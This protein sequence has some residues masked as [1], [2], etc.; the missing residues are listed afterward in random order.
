MATR[1]V[2]SIGN[3]PIENINITS[4]AGKVVSGYANCWEL[5]CSAVIQSAI[6]VG[7]KVES[8][9]RRYLV[10]SKSGLLLVVCGDA[11]STTLAPSNGAANSLRSF[12]TI[13]AWASESPIN[14]ITSDFVWKGEVY[15]EG[16]GPNNEWKLTSSIALT[17]RICDETR[18]FEL[19][20]AEGS[21]VIDY[22]NLNNE[23]ARY[24][25]Q[26]GVAILFTGNYTNFVYMINRSN[27]EGGVPGTPN[28]SKSII[29]FYGLQIK[30]ADKL[31]STSLCIGSADQD[32]AVLP[33]FES[34]IIYDASSR[35]S[36]IPDIKNSIFY[37]DGASVFSQNSFELRMNSCTVVNIGAS[38]GMCQLS[39]Y[40]A[41]NSHSFNN[42]VFVGFSPI[43]S[44]GAKVER[45][46]TTNNATNLPDAG[47]V[48]PNS[49]FN[50]VAADQFVSLNPADLDFR[51]KI[52]SVL[53]GAGSALGNK[54][55]NSV[56]FLGRPRSPAN[57]SIGAI[58]SVWSPL[59]QVVLQ[60]D[61]TIS[62]GIAR[63]IERGIV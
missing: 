33:S 60:S 10:L 39:N 40:A 3:R 57:P 41:N 18:Y 1:V 13:N 50:I 25:P 7:D 45:A 54:Y 31:A 4:V 58:E 30:K 32:R 59:N 14:L 5:T 36:A 51:L 11:F 28:L 37:L 56:D 26:N 44:N 42:S 21:S 61:Q 55:N 16:S 12:S 48:S 43:I 49:I 53:I 2:M 46:K 22:L 62:K 35:A 38:V 34:C 24:S 17:N 20:P 6:R 9:G 15:K 19:S 29:K 52:G 8:S 63:G 23:A 47:F 27:A